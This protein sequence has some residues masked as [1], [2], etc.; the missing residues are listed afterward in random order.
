MAERFTADLL[1]II[2]VLLAAAF[3]GFLIGYYVRK[4]MKCKGC[5]ALEEENAGMKNRIDLLEKENSDYRQRSDLLAKEV[6]T[7]KEEIKR[8][9]EAK[10]ARAVRKP[11][12]AP[13]RKKETP[14]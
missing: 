12:K 13:A 9:R 8:I 2:I 14:K 1:F 4:S 3:L 10:P 6:D 7:L 5:A 11:V